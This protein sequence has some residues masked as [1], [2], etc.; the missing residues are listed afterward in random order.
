M[1]TTNIVTIADS[2][3]PGII[4]IFFIIA[5][6]FNLRKYISYK[7]NNTHNDGKN[8]NPYKHR[9]SGIIILGLMGI[10]LITLS[11]YLLIVRPESQPR[12]KLEQLQEIFNPE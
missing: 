11:V 10:F 2:I 6:S 8:L 9:I 4:G 1:S 12:T 3:V 5:S 7:K